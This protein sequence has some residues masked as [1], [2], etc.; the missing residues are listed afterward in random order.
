MSMLLREALARVW[1]CVCRLLMSC[2]NHFVCFA[3]R[4]DFGAIMHI[5][6]HAPLYVTK[7]TVIYKLTREKPAAMARAGDA[8]AWGVS[9]V[10][11][12]TF[13]LL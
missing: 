8:L 13:N 9:G 11:L 4:G 6:I 3:F 5:D 1:A 2:R 12:Q 10:L 7:S